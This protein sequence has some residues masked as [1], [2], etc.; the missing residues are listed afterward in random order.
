[1]PIS[2]RRAWCWWAAR[3]RGRAP[4]F[5][6]GGR[7][8]G[9]G[10]GAVG[11]GGGGV[12]GAAGDPAA[13]GREERDFAGAAERVADCGPAGGR[14]DGARGFGDAAAERRG[15]GGWERG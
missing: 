14:G 5:C 13:R 10:G 12:P 3:A 15:V 7:P 8:G 1:M 9:G 2:G 11:G 6:G 4:Q